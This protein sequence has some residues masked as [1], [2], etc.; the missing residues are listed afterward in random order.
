MQAIRQSEVRAPDGPRIVTAG[1]A[2]FATVFGAGFVL[3]TLRVLLVVPRLG[4]RVAELLEMPLMLLVICGAAGWI[5]RRFAL[6]P[7][8]RVRLA[9]GVLALVLLLAVE[10]AVVLALRGLTWREYVAT[11][12]P[13]SGTAYIALLGVFALM[14]WLVGCRRRSDDPAEPE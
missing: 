8:P 3:G 10:F 6:P 4:E 7:V 1:A 11:R 13:V 12:D 5:V 9:V 14:P 2:Y